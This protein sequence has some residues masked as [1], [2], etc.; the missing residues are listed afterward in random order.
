MAMEYIWSITGMSKDPASGGV[1]QI[2]WLCSGS[3]H[4]PL[5]SF[6]AKISGTTKHTPDASSA[7]YITF[8]DIQEPIA[9]N[10][11][12]SVINKAQTEQDTLEMATHTRGLPW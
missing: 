7:D 3:E 6:M 4:T 12:W 8:D 5:A 11:V 1:H 2:D 9:L 10:W